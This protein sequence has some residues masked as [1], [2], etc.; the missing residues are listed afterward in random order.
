MM[1]I[2]YFPRLAAAFLLSG[3]AWL[4][5]LICGTLFSMAEALSP[6]T[7]REEMDLDPNGTR[8]HFG[9]EFAKRAAKSALPEK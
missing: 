3:L 4:T 5:G 1:R 6:D 8:S 2:L 9:R 7:K